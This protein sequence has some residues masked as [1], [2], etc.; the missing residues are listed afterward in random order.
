MLDD[1][2]LIV[3][4]L[5]C[6][7]AAVAVLRSAL[8]RRV[9]ADLIALLAVSG[10]LATGERV[11]AA[12]V[13]L[14]LATG[15]GLEAV[16]SRRAKRELTALLDRQ[17]RTAHRVVDGA[18]EQVPLSE[19]VVGDTVAV[20]TAEVV[21]VDGRLTSDS[22]TIDQSVLTGEPLPVDLALGDTI[23]SGTC[24]AGGN[25]EML[26]TANADQSTYA[27]I[28]RLVEQAGATNAP[29]VRL[30]D[31]VALGFLPLTLV[32]A[33]AAWAWS[34]EVARAVAVLVVATPCPLILA[35]P[36][37]IFAGLSSAA[38]LGIVIK[39]G[40]VLER[41]ARATGLMLDKTGT[42]TA[43]RPEVV[44]VI[45]AAGADEDEVLRIAASVDHMSSHVIAD[46]IVR[47]ANRR[48]LPLD[49]VEDVAELAGRGTV[50]TLDGREVRVGRATWLGVDEQTQF[51]RD[52]FRQAELHD[53]T[54]VVVEVDGVAIGAILVADRIRS[55]SARTLR[56][57]RTLGIERVVLL[58]GD[59][60]EPAGVVGSLVGVD[61]VIARCTPEDKVEAVLAERA[62]RVTIMVGD[63]INDAPALAAADIGIAMGSSGGSAATESADVVVAVN[64]VD[65]VGD[66]V[67]IAQRV[68]RLARQSVVIGMGCSLIAM[69][70]AAFGLLPATWGALVQ[71]LIDVIAILNSLRAMSGHLQGPRLTGLD[72]EMAHRFSIEHAQLES[73]LDHLLRLAE[74]LGGEADPSAAADEALRLLRDVLEPHELAEELELY[75]VLEAAIGGHEPMSTLSR[76]H[77]EISRLINRLE[78]ATERIDGPMTKGDVDEIRRLLYGLHAILAL[79]MAQEEE[80]FLSLAGPIDT[81][82]GTASDA[83][84][85]GVEHLTGSSAT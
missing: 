38:R 57:L 46:G 3:G 48:G 49:D 10:A 68:V 26:V 9:G 40:P 11:A 64:R 71:E 1:L 70:A 73:E 43:G 59:R 69:A 6:G 81:A 33:G 12:L 55:D 36:I 72:A 24:N 30:A 29:M 16:A 76:S 77:R 20:A 44:N 21:G 74:R 31:Q 15:L 66:A 53:A 22:A 5:G 47:A 34:G 61:E 14:M 2:L 37:A 27:G 67:A 32:V 4:V 50:G 63:G 41:L 35:V 79:H 78:V 7:L 58:T 56:W 51:G 52:V 80:G 83:P 85:S 13:S 62:D 45:S 42:I 19:I 17:P 60:A 18:V 82:S 75:P 28:I 39:G 8:H 54:V 23:R 25:F 84:A 65:R